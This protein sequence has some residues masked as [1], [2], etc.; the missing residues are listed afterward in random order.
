MPVVLV[1]ARSLSVSLDEEVDSVEVVRMLDFEV[2][3]ADELLESLVDLDEV[4]RFRVFSTLDRD[5]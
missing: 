5:S 1:M 2:F 4:C 3:E